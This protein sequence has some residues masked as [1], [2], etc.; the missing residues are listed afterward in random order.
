MNLLLPALLRLF[1]LFSLCFGASVTAQEFL[2]PLVAF[3]PTLRALDGQTVEVRYEIAKG[4]YLYRDKFRVHAADP[5]RVWGHCSC[6]RARKRTMTPSG[7]PRC[8]TRKGIP[9]ARGAQQFRPA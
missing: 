1:L 3:K 8:T 9:S 6:R 5:R 4:Y 2:D 7:A